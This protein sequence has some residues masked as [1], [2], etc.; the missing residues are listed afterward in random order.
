MVMDMLV[1]R[2]HC[3]KAPTVEKNR[4]VQLA[5]YDWNC[6]SGKQRWLREVLPALTFESHGKENMSNILAYL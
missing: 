5:L 1:H 4:W 3:W 2:R 6:L